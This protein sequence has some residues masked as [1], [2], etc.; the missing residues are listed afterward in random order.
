MEI[1]KAICKECKHVLIKKHRP[2]NDLCW[3]NMF[4]TR[5]RLI[6]TVNA[7]TGEAGFADEVG[8]TVDE[9]E[10]SRCRNEGDCEEFEAKGSGLIAKICKLCGKESE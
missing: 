10:F 8:G 6:S 3:S 7:V 5:H 2:D 1:P 9:H 4:C